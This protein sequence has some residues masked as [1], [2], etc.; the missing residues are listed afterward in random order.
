[1]TVGKLA[2][3]NVLFDPDYQDRRLTLELNNA[4]LYSA[5]DYVSLLARAY[6]KPVSTNAIFVTNDNTTKRRDYEDYV[7]K[8]F[9]LTNTYT[10]QELQEIA[11]MVRSVTDIRRVFTINSLNALVIR[12]TVDQIALA[13]KVIEDVDKSRAE[14][15]I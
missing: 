11:T 2:G 8:T 9:Y 3:I 5:L 14:V 12:A 13:E 1:E 4:T 6:W 7:V 10:A 15:I